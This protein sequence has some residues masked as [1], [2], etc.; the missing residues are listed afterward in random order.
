[1][2]EIVAAERRISQEIHGEMRLTAGVAT[3]AALPLSYGQE[4][5]TLTLAGNGASTYQAESPPCR[6]V[7]LNIVRRTHGV[8][9]GIYGMFSRPVA[10]KSAGAPGGF[11]IHRGRVRH[12]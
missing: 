10:G 3:P 1:M 12:L 9:L 8:R 5:A 11:G 4:I 6:P 7:P 2:G